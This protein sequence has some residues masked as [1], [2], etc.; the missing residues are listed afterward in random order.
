M[1][2]SITIK[3]ERATTS[4][5]GKY[6]CKIAGIINFEG[7]GSSGPFDTEEE[8]IQA[9]CKEWSGQVFMVGRGEL[10]APRLNG[11]ALIDQC[12]QN[13][14]EETHLDS[15]VDTWLL[16]VTK[17]HEKDLSAM[18]SKTFSEWLEKYGF[19]HYWEIIKVTRI[20]NIDVK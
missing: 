12:Y 17:G 7:L 15:V 5:V 10:R 14:L 8:A 4:K 16:N 13:F 6:F 1:Q 9:G 2:D 18:I 20:I 3:D 19:D 11:Y